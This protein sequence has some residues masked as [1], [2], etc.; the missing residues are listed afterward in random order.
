MTDQHD[1]VIE[2][3]K[4]SV[5]Q[6]SFLQNTNVGTATLLQSQRGFEAEH[7]IQEL[8]T[9]EDCKK[10]KADT[11]ERMTGVKEGLRKLE[12]TLEKAARIANEVRSD[13]VRSLSTLF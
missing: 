8:V 2:N 11:E 12:K 9:S 3:V 7:A 4:N 5:Q 1:K 10:V 13:V 6:F